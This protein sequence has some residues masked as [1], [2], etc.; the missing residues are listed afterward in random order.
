MPG[1]LFRI[2]CFD[3]P[4]KPEC[5]GYAPRYH[6]YVHDN[7]FGGREKLRKSYLT[8]VVKLRNLDPSPLKE[9]EGRKLG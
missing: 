4:R 9:R 8:N 6:L 5:A 3:Y 1:W 7:T 2:V